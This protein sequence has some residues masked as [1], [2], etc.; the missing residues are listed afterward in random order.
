M[1]HLIITSITV[2][3]FGNSCF[4]VNS[5]D[6]DQTLQSALFD[7]GLYCGKLLF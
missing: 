6:P 3:V 4:K 1:V 7:Q 2:T 5:I